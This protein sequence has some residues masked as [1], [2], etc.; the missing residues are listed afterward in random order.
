MKV[1]NVAKRVSW[2]FIFNHVS[3]GEGMGFRI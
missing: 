1:S 2:T 3:H